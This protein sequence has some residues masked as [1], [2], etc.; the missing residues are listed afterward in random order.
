MI[1]FQ[2]TPVKFTGWIG[3]SL[4]VG[5]LYVSI[6]DWRVIKSK[7]QELNFAE[8]LVLDSQCR[9]AIPVLEE[10]DDH[11]P[12][13]IRILNLTKDCQEQLGLTRGL[14]L[15]QTQLQAAH[16]K[17]GVI[18]DLSRLVFSYHYYSR[19]HDLDRWVTNPPSQRRL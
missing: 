19:W 7:P 4:I 14:T 6:K 3:I 17:Y 16:E 9:K 18:G 8:K 5:L 11:I 10:L 1:L 12:K 13:S 15:T 2:N